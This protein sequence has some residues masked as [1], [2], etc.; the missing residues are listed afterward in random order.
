MKSLFSSRRSPQQQMAATSDSSHHFRLKEIIC[1]LQEKSESLASCR[2][3][4]SLTQREIKE[5]C[6]SLYSSFHSNN[7]SSS[8]SLITLLGNVKAVR[9][10]PEPPSNVPPLCETIN[11]SPFH[12][13]IH[14]E[15]RNVPI[16]RVIHLSQ[17]R[18]QL[19][20]LVLYASADSLDEVLQECGGDKCTDSF[21]WSELHS[22]HVTK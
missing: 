14:L 22:L 6:S 21:L 1:L 15:L 10:L 2:S 12:R 4:L 7:E 18:S 17:L 13:L 20:H 11:L 3:R 19:S 8:S 9:I 5:I 16:T